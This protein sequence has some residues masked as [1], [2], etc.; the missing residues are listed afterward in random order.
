MKAFRPRAQRFDVF[1][2]DDVVWFEALDS[3]YC[4]CP[5]AII[6]PLLL[7][8]DPQKQVIRESVEGCSPI[9]TLAQTRGLGLGFKTGQAGS[10]SREPGQPPPRPP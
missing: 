1:D 9:L 7:T 3:I 8:T 6:G 5:T 4:H 2:L 10:A